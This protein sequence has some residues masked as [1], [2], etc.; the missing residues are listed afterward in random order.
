VVFSIHNLLVEDHIA[1]R[2]L[3]ALRGVSMGTE[4]TA[5]PYEVLRRQST[6]EGTRREPPKSIAGKGK[7][8]GDLVSPIVEEIDWKSLVWS[9][10]TATSGSDGPTASTSDYLPNVDTRSNNQS[11]AVCLRC[12]AASWRLRID[13]DVCACP[14]NGQPDGYLR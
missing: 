1:I 4:A 12:P 14:G 7:T 5:I 3:A 10:W 8:L 2:P 11:G 6:R 9:S 13:A